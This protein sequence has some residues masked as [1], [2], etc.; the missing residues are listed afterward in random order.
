MQHGQ[1]AKVLQIPDNEEGGAHFDGVTSCESLAWYHVSLKKF[2]YL[3][4]SERR[5]LL[6]RKCFQFDKNPVHAFC[7]KMHYACGL[8]C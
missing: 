5:F 4:V 1:L 6:L 2:Q 3:R 8:N 7:V